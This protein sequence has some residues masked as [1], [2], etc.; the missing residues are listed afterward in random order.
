MSGGKSQDI[1]QELQ[2]PVPEKAHEENKLRE[3]RSYM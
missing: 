1:P 2:C 3:A